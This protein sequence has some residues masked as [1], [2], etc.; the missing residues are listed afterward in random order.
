V[1]KD[2]LGSTV[3]LTGPTQTVTG[4]YSYEPYG[5]ST[6]TYGTSINGY[7]FA[8][9]PYDF[10]NLYF[11]RNRY[12][13][14]SIARFISRDPAGGGVDPYVYAGDDPIDFSDPTGSGFLPLPILGIGQYM[15]PGNTD[16]PGGYYGAS[17]GYGAVEAG[18][19]IALDF[20]SVGFGGVGKILVNG[21]R[22]GN[23]DGVPTLV[24]D[25]AGPGACSQYSQEC[26]QSGGRDAY[27]CH[28][29]PCCRAFGDNPVDDAVRGCLLGFE[30]ACRAPAM[31][32]H[33]RL[34]AH[35]YCYA[36]QGKFFFG[37][38]LLFHFTSLPPECGGV[39]QYIQ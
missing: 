28:A 6:H 5:A 2:A 9:Q 38:G 37:L 26:Q 21:S 27:A 30:A 8:G 10:N 4:L 13:L 22:M 31:N 15:G 7:L 23:A 19:G 39:Q 12:Y 16:N 17:Y 35:Y 32:P 25:A 29:E 20:G 14:P 18:I 33:C 36:T 34:G 24:S 1:L 11:M 3:G